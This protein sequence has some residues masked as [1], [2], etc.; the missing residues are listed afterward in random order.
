MRPKSGG[1]NMTSQRA[2]I[3][4][5]PLRRAERRAAEF[6]DLRAELEDVRVS[7]DTPLGLEKILDLAPRRWRNETMASTPRKVV[8]VPDRLVNIVL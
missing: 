1:G 8:V 3:V 2:D 6:A 4:I 5:A 7:L